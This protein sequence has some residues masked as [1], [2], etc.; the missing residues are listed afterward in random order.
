MRNEDDSD[1]GEAGENLKLKQ[2]VWFVIPHKGGFVVDKTY[3]PR[4]M[5]GFPTFKSMKKAI[6]Y[7]RQDAEYHGYLSKMAELEAEVA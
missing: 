2:P 6:A 4:Q 5:R 1:E 3:A 7:G